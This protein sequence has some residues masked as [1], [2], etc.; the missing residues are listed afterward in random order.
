VATREPLL[1]SFA[2]MIR[3]RFDSRSGVS[4]LSAPALGTPVV[5][6]SDSS[7]WVMRSAAAVSTTGQ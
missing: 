1:A 3:I 5:D 2:G 7:G 4:S 6:A